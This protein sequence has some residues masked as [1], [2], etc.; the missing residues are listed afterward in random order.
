MLSIPQSAYAG[1]KPSA[2]DIALVNRITWGV[3]ATEMQRVQAMG[4]ENW[5]QSQLHPGPGDRLPP[6]A[7]AAIG[8]LAMEHRSPADLARDLA[9][10]VDAAKAMQAPVG[11][12]PVPANGAAALASMPSTPGGFTMAS[13]QSTPMQSPAPLAVRPQDIRNAY[14]GDA[15]RQDQA[16]LILRDLYSTD[17]LREQ[18][19]AFWL[20]HFNVYVDKGEI[21]I[22]LADYEDHAIRPNSLGN[23]RTLLEATL[24]SSAMLQYLDNAQNAAGHIN[25]NYARE[26][27]ELHTMGVGSGY[28]QKDVQ[29]L[30]RIL[31]GVGVSNPKAPAPNPQKL[32]QGAIRD[33]M[34]AF[35]PARHDKGE[36]LFLGHVITGSG[37]DE[38]RQ[39]LDILCAQPATARHISKQI[40]QYFFEMGDRRAVRRVH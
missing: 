23:F 22:F 4:I 27:M 5:L 1:D 15:Y 37:Y 29:E 2:E 3:N 9:D 24:R 6:R 7:Q 11:T 16:R 10:R 18:M 39:A 35:Y 40:A 33:G 14:L 21:R 36:K 25:E 38:V 26:I 8:A 28:S 30:A 19:T 20:N 32:A 31:T 17:Q 13:L 34:F 12:A